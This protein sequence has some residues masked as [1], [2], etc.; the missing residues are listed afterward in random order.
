[1]N[2]E[3][4]ILSTLDIRILKYLKEERTTTQILDNF[5][6]YYSQYKRHL[7]RI[8]KY[9]NR[10][11]ISNIVFVKINNKGLKILGDFNGI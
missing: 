1:M 6:F 10:R 7:E 4:I 11:H 3:K 9:V 5:C 8:K 2:R